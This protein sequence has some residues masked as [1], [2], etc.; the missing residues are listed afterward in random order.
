MEKYFSKRLR[1]SVESHSVEQPSQSAEVNILNNNVELEVNPNEVEIDENDIVADPG[2]RKPIDSFN[3]NMRDRIRREYVAKGPCQPKGHN[4]PKKKY[5]KDNRGFRGAWFDDFDCL[6]YSV[7]KDATYCFCCFLFKRNV[8]SPG[9]E[10][11]T[12]NGFFQLEKSSR[13]I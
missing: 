1:S 3:V 6:Q 5:G 8:L 10:A 4:F 13:E 12:K 2:L 9:D 7:S 11:F